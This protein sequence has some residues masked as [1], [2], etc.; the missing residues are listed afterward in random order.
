MRKFLRNFKNKSPM[1]AK[2]KASLV[3][4]DV[5]CVPKQEILRSQMSIVLEVRSMAI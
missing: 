2:I 3:A 4:A 5:K 1:Q